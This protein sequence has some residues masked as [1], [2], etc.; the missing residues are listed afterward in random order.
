MLPHQAHEELS[1]VV[2]VPFPPESCLSGAAGS[3]NASTT[4]SFVYRLPFR[5]G[6]PPANPT[7]RERL[8]LHFGAVD[9]QATVMVNGK[10]AG[11][12]RGG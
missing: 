9:W 6:G 8:M 2:L 11:Q 5:L 10:E 1:G 3:F 7:V 12:H 4:S